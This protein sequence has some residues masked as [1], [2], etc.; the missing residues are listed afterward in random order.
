MVFNKVDP[1]ASCGPGRLSFCYRPG[2]TIPIIPH[3]LPPSIFS[4][5]LN[6]L[7]LKGGKAIAEVLK[8]NKSIEKIG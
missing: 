2:N 6:E 8:V 3:L 7:G 5:G 1:L 4:L